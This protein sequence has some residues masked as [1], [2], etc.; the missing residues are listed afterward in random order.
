MQIELEVIEGNVRAMSLYEKMGF[1]IVAATPNAIKLED[2]NLL[3][4]FLMVKPL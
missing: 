1:E 4:E 3:K 2:G